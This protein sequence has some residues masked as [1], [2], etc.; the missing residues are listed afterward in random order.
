MPPALTVL[1][2]NFE[3][4]IRGG[5]QLYLRDVALELLRRGHRPF[6]YSPRLGSV[7][8]ELIAATVPVVDDL[9][10]VTVKPDV[11]HGHHNHETLTALLRFPG[12][13]AVRLC[14]GWWDEPPQPFP[15]ILRYVAVDD[16]TR[17]RCVTDWGIPEERLE[18]LLNFVD[19][20]RFSVRSALPPRPARAL[21]F[22]NTARG[23]LGAVRDACAAAGI[24]VEA[25]GHDIGR[26]TADPARLLRQYDLVFAKARAAIE[27]LA[28]GSA[29]VLCD[30]AGVG[31][32]VSTANV[33]HLRRLNFGLRTLQAPIARDVIAREVARYDPRDAREVTAYIRAAADADAAIDRLVEIYREVIAEHAAAGVEGG[34]DLR[35]ASLYLERVGARLRWPETPRGAFYLALRSMQLQLGRLPGVSVLGRCAWAKRVARFAR[36]RWRRG[37]SGRR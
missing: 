36:A 20:R 3:L 31:P 7:A 4:A 29:V 8:H 27:A 12:V 2:T 17:D 5:S 37:V 11:I 9:S 24:A 1:L 19:L 21:V 33:R 34:D 13:P 28:S 22:S 18:V 14:H 10:R 35:A 25:A 15:R 30:A 32:M 16:T 26:A 23:H 6:V